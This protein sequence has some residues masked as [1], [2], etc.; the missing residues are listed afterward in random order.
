MPCLGIQLAFLYT[1]TNKSRCTQICPT[2]TML[3]LSRG[4]LCLNEQ[5]WKQ[6]EIPISLSCRGLRHVLSVKEDVWNDRHDWELCFH[7]LLAACVR[8][9][10]H[11]FPASRDSERPNFSLS[12]HL[13]LH[14]YNVT[15]CSK[16]RKWEALMK[17]CVFLDCWTLSSTL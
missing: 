9:M 2:S 7:Q 3:R 5:K 6:A 15:L 16:G 14:D 12:S 13:C 8:A 11:M 10:I 17:S 1:V 4:C